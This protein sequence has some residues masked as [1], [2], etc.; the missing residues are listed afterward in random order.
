MF[1]W[2]LAC[3]CLY[4]GFRLHAIL[5]THGSAVYCVLVLLP[6]G[7]AFTSLQDLNAHNLNAHTSVLSRRS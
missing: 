5:C 7:I 6:V 4:V 1:K 2:L 3:I